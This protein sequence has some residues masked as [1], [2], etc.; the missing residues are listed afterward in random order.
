MNHHENLKSTK[1]CVNAEMRSFAGGDVVD[2]P[3]Q[4]VEKYGHLFATGDRKFFAGDCIPLYVLELRFAA[5]SVSLCHFWHG[6]N[7][8]LHPGK[9]RQ[10]LVKKS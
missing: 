7:G 2:T 3:R 9:L 8:G 4:G 5:L 6:E 10:T 1:K